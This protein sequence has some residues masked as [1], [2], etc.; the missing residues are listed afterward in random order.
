MSPSGKVFNDS[1]IGSAKAMRELSA[2][3]RETGVIQGH[4]ASFSSKKRSAFLQALEEMIQAI[5]RKS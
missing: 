5:K 2:Y 3:L 4:N 1:N